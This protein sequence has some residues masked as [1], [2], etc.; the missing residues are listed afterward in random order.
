MFNADLSQQARKYL[1]KLAAEDR[2]K[3]AKKIG[4]LEANPFSRGMNLKKLGGIV[5][6]YRLRIGSIRVLMTIDVSA[7]AIFIFKIRPRGDVY[8]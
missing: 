4:E 1:R 7:K 3:V 2:K 6:G 8:K 5:N